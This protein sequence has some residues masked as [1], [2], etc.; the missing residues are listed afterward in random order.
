MSNVDALILA[1]GLSRRMGTNKLLLPLGETTVI[2]QFLKTF[3]YHFFS[4]VIVIASDEQVT[5]IARK[6]TVKV[7]NNNN[8]AAGI[9]GSIR[10]GLA[11][12]KA[13]DGFL[14][15]V[16]DQ[17]FLTHEIFQKLLTCFSADIRNIVFPEVNGTP[18]NPVIFPATLRADL[19]SLQGDN[20]GRTLYSR[21]PDITRSVQFNSAE[22]FLDIDTP[23]TYQE[24]VVRWN[25]TNS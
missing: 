12:S 22:D 3:P 23:Q 19:L 10:H 1:S 11:A 24:A 17:P 25:Q 5:E 14:F 18:R 15:T 6:H 7:C 16:A 4:S 21:H 9:S 8:P 2:D 20:G 13:T